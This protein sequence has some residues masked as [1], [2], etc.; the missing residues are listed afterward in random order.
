M[1][2]KDL[3]KEVNDHCQE[4]FMEG[5]I[6]EGFSEATWLQCWRNRAVKEAIDV[7]YQGMYSRT[8]LRSF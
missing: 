4:L 5:N 7:F 1:K 2:I 8:S 3:P 6:Q